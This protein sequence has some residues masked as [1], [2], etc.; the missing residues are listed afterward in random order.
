M[1]DLHSNYTSSSTCWSLLIPSNRFGSK[2]VVPHH[3][4][5]LLLTLLTYQICSLHHLKLLLGFQLVRRKCNT[6]D[7][8]WRGGARACSY[9]RAWVGRAR[10]KWKWRIRPVDF[11]I[12]HRAFFQVLFVTGCFEYFFNVILFLWRLFLRNKFILYVLQW[13]GFNLHNCICVVPISRIIN[14]K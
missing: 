5:G 10:L 11:D 13:V 12:R 2:S 4:T 8:R 6:I 7:D 3:F 14:V 9:V 1:H